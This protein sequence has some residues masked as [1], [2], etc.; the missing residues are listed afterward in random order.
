MKLM[1]H[2]RNLEKKEIKSWMAVKLARK[3]K[4]K[5]FVNTIIDFKILSISNYDYFYQG[6][7]SKKINKKK[8]ESKNKTGSKSETGH[9]KEN[10]SD[11]HYNHESKYHKEKKSKKHHKTKA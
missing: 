8:G 5:R 1:V 3:I 7:K 11:S 9:N 6:S 4:L 10:K 2:L